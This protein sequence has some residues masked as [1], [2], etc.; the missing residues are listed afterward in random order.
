[1]FFIPAYPF[2]S[3]MITA[4]DVVALWGCACTAAARTWAWPSLAAL[5]HT[6]EGTRPLPDWA[7][8]A[9]RLVRLCMG[10]H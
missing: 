9:T 7:E 4:V 6:V 2:W 1:M 5:G 3:L 10:G 8:P